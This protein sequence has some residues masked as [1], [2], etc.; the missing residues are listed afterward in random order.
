[1]PRAG[2]PD[3]RYDRDAGA[4][5]RLASRSEAFLHGVLLHQWPAPTLAPDTRPL[6][7]HLFQGSPPRKVPYYAGNYRGDPRWFCLVDFNVGVRSDPLVGV[8]AAQVPRQVRLLGGAI[9]DAIKSVE[10]QFAS[11]PGMAAAI[12]AATVA[13]LAASAF[14][15]FLTIH[16]YVDGNGHV[17][18]GLVTSLMFHFGYVAAGWRVDP[19]PDHPDYPQMIYEHRRGQ[20]AAL[21]NYFLSIMSVAT[22]DP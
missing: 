9:A 15:N 6:H 11:A 22:T 10:A 12:R 7:L 18:R 20:T 1:M 21:E 19:R 5:R 14:V 3:W 2:C 13:R 17:A 8:P 4:L 16:P